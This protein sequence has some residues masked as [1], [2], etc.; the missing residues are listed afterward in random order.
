[1]ITRMIESSVAGF[2][3]T[4]P[5]SYFMN[6]GDGWKLTRP[7]TSLPPRKI[8]EESVQP[9]EEFAEQSLSSKTIDRATYAAHFGYGATV[10]SLFGLKRR[11]EPFAKNVC[12]GILFGIAVWVVS[13]F[14]W[15]PAIESRAAGVRQT[16]RV[17]FIMFFAHVVWGASLGACSYPLQKVERKIWSKP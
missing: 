5:M 7:G 10:G 1:M 4:I 17:N 15:L 14:G 3:A 11:D 8:T 9:V 13:Y 2:V 6:W 12:S 16:R